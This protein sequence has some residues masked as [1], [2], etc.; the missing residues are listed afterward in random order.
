MLDDKT[1]KVLMQKFQVRLTQTQQL[2]LAVWGPSLEVVRKTFR[3]LSYSEFR[4]I[5]ESALLDPEYS[6]SVSEVK[7]P[8]F[9]PEDGIVD[10]TGKWHDQAGVWISE[11]ET[12]EPT[13][14]PME[15]LPDDLKLRLRAEQCGAQPLP[16]FDSLHKVMGFDFDKD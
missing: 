10:F 2:E 4:E 8:T 1:T 7:D 14:D 12:Y 6:A 15:I 11:G 16:G 9:V 13:G 5:M 3:Q